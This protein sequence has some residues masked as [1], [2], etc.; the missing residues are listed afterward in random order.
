MLNH[1]FFAIL[2][3]DLLLEKEDKESKVGRKET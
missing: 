3:A 1:E 2:V